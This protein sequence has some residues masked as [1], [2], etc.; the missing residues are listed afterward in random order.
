MNDCTIAAHKAIGG[1]VIA[2]GLHGIL[3]KDVEEQYGPTIVEFA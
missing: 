3:Y 1:S 2:W